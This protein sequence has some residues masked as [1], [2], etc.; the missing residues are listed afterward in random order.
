MAS[1][2]GLDETCIEITRSSSALVGSPDA[3]KHEHWGDKGLHSEAH[4]DL[5][6]FPILSS[7]THQTLLSQDNKV[8]IVLAHLQL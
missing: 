5:K 8:P 2:K 6:R 7:I 4:G 1:V 3:I